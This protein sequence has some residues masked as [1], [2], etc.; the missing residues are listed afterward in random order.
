LEGVG[1]AVGGWTDSISQ[2]VVGLN[3]LVAKAIVIG[4]STPAIAGN[5]FVSGG[6]TACVSI[7][8]MI[9]DW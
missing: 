2:S 3:L 5:T 4:R 8:V 9:S 1:N 6:D 7:S